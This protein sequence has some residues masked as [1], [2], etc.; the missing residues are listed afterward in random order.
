MKPS[1]VFDTIQAT[2]DDLIQELD[3]KIQNMTLIN[4]LRL[5]HQ[6]FHSLFFNQ[7]LSG[8]L[9][10][11]FWNENVQ[12]YEDLNVAKQYVIFKESNVTMDDL[13]SLLIVYEPPLFC[14]TTHD[15]FKYLNKQQL[16]RK[17]CLF[18]KGLKLLFNVALKPI[19]Y[20]F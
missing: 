4:G 2:F 9:L 8:S 10:L 17:F 19:L 12:G 3:P 6:T 15:P 20:P 18:E 1:I 13:Q 14:F 16:D 11:T 7:E 5:Y